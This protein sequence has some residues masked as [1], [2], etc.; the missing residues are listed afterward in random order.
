ALPFGDATVFRVICSPRAFGR[1]DCHLMANRAGHPITCQRAIVAQPMQA[2]IARITYRVQRFAPKW[3]AKPC[4]CLA[5]DRELALAHHPMAAKAGI[6]NRGGRLRMKH[7][8]L[9]R[10]LGE[11]KRIAA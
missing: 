11:E 6:L 8:R 5:I 10:E 3:L 2:M 4:R 7:L 1:A 9:A